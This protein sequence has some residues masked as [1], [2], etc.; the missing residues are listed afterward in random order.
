RGSSDDIR[1]A[2]TDLNTKLSD[3]IRDARETIKTESAKL[4]QEQ[5]DE[6]DKIAEINQKKYKHEA[7]RVAAIQAVHQ[8][9]ADTIK[10]SEELIAE[11]QNVLDRSIAARATLTKS[12]QDEKK[13]LITLA[14]DYD[15]VANKLKDANKNLDDLQ[16]QRS[17]FISGLKEQYAAPPDISDPMTQQIADAKD[18]IKDAKANL[19]EAKNAVEPDMAAI[20]QAQ[21]AVL[22]AQS[23]FDDL[24][25][26]KVLNAKGT[27]VDLLATY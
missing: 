20:D 19:A 21:K 13:E 23:A 16:K 14:N 4:R 7:D 10:K 24:V 12:L 11:N 15:R 3:A 18:K 8:Q 25:A 6:A 27:G 22:D 1:G 17:D 2:F 5:S 26:G 9:Y